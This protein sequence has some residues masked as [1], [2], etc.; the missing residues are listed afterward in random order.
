M[1]IGIIG[2]DGNYI[3]Y[4][5]LEAVLAQPGVE[6][7]WFVDAGLTEAKRRRLYGRR[8]QV[9]WS[10]RLRERLGGWRRRKA[11]VL[12]CRQ[13]CAQ[14]GIP[15]LLPEGQSINSGLPASMYAAPEVE[16]ALVV[17]CDQLLD[18]QGLR[19]SRGLVINYHYS[20]LPAYRG[21]FVAFWQWFNREPY[22]GFSFHEVNLGVDTGRPRYQ[23][24]VDY[25]PDEP[26]ESVRRRLVDQS[27]AQMG[28]LLECLRDGS[29]HLLDL[30]QQPSYYPAKRY[31]A[32]MTLEPQRTVDE[33]CAVFE[34][35]G[36]LKLPNGRRI[37]RIVARS[38]ERI[39]AMALGRKGIAVPL[40]DGHLVVSP[41]PRLPFW[42]L[43]LLRRRRLAAL[44]SPD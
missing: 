2:E 7:R 34:R 10:A 16:H 38:S 4:R 19:I 8:H 32:L 33:V 15:Y 25:S 14:H 22:M 18:E 3:S 12:S 29:S 27:A 24:T 43:R 44:V 20:L 23:G 17:G 28:G 40:K 30:G 5:M 37:A 21:K 26:F 1:Q 6:I 42:L 36:W 39:P 31:H 11:P 13:L 35:L 9:S 41:S